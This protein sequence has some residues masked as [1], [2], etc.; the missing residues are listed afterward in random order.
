MATSFCTVLPVPLGWQIWPEDTCTGWMTKE[1]FSLGAHSCCPPA[2][3]FLPFIGKHV[4]FH[5][6]IPFPSQRRQQM[7]KIWDADHYS[8]DQTFHSMLGL[9]LRLDVPLSIICK[10]FIL[11]EFHLWYTSVSVGML[12]VATKPKISVI[13]N[14]IFSF[15][16]SSLLHEWLLL[17]FV[18]IGTILS[19]QV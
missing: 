11:S 10:L 3:C 14:L 6:S 16:H 12:E 7:K 1:R 8:C 18:C 4:A 9:L 15:H 19:F 2:V 13:E 5:T 17:S